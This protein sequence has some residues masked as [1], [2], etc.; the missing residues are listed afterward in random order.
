MDSPKVA[1]VLNKLREHNLL[2]E[3]ETVNKAV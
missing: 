1:A 2:V 3:E